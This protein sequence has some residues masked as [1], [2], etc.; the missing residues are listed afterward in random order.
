[1]ADID[2]KNQI[3]SVIL[4]LAT[5][6]KDENKANN[7]ELINKL[8]QRFDYSEDIYRSEM[9]LASFNFADIAAMPWF[10]RNKV[11]DTENQNII[12]Y[13]YNGT[14]SHYLRRIIT[15]EEGTPCSGDKVSFITKK[16]KEAI[17]TGESQSLYATYEGCER[18]EQERWNEQAYWSPKTFK[19]TNEVI[20]AFWK[21]YRLEE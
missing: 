17:V 21:W 11:K 4:S 16:V 8:Q 19:D 14:F 9:I 7:A 13:I 2:F 15:R 5:S 12:K 3:E 18:I 6:F 1:M 20:T 10:A